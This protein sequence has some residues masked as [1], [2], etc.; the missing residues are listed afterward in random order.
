LAALALI[1][2]AGTWLSRTPPAPVSVQKFELTTS[3]D[4]VRISPDGK[5]L[6]GIGRNP[7]GQF[8]LWLHSL[9]SGERVAMP[10]TE[11]VDPNAVFW[12]PDSSRVAFQA[13][14]VLHV[15]DLTGAPPKTIAE[16]E[17]QIRGG[18]WSP[19]DVILVGNTAG[20]IRRV[21]AAGGR[22]TEVT[23]LDASRQEESHRF[24]F[25]LPN[26]EDFLFTVRGRDGYHAIQVGNLESG[27][28]TEV[29][30]AFSSLAYAEPGYLLYLRDD[31]LLGQPFDPASR[32][33]E[34]SPT[35]IASG[36]AC[37]EPRRPRAFLPISLG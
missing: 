20:A 21:S 12:A 9:A 28:L 15:A 3:M 2:A 31:V 27:D 35:T 18:T 30:T 10:G 33:I 19:N 24:P 7:S 16:I 34:G 13:K 25:F 14:G 37:L 29:L 8:V 4:G 11:Y 36:D 26:G 23:A 6:V 17:G 22:V 5:H 1:L 32:S